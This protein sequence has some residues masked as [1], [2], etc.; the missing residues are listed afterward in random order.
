MKASL[1][2]LLNVL[3]LGFFVSSLEA[4]D[5]VTELA[6]VEALGQLKAV[7]AMY[8][9]DGNASTIKAGETKTIYFDALDYKGAPTRVFAWLG[10][11]E[12]ASAAKPVPAVVLVQ[13]GGGT[14]FKDWVRMW[15]E[16]GYAAISIAVEGQTDERIKER[17]PGKWARH[18][19]AGPS[20]KG[21]YA[22][23]G[24][25]FKDQWM[26][27]AVAD[28]V[29]ANSLLRSLPEVDADNVGLMG[30]SWGGIITSTVIGIDTRFAFAIPTYGIG[31]LHRIDNQ[32]KRALGDDSLFQEVWDP[33]VRI[34]R[35]SMPAL[36]LSWPRDKHFA[37][38]IQADTYEAAP[39]VRMVSLVP[40]MKHSHMHGWSRP[41]SYA[42]ADSIVKTG[43]PWCVQTSVETDGNDVTVEFNCSKP[44]RSASLLAN[45][46][47]GHTSNRD[48]SETVAELNSNENGSWTVKASLPP[49]ASGWF[50]NIKTSGGDLDGDEDGLT[51][52]FG[53][54]DAELIASSDYSE[55]GVN[56]LSVN[57]QEEDSLPNVLIIGDSISIG[58]TPVVKELLADVANVQRVDGN[59]GDTNRGLALLDSWLK[60][61]QWDVIHFNWG[62]H[63][64][65]YRHPDSKTSGRRDKINGTV[66]VPLDEYRKNLESLVGQLEATGTTLIWANTTFVP[67]GEAGRFAGDELK[68][69]KVA[70]E[71]MNRHNVVTDDLH[72]MTSTF[73]PSLFVKPGNVHYTKE[74]YA[75]IAA[76]V[77]EQIRV[78]L[79]Q[80]Q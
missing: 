32:Y 22:D 57:D 53:Y 77:A 42:F 39:G 43:K 74:G 17:P 64:L 56:L 16:R 54:N 67:E 29:L 34:S 69:N 68:Y 79:I 13:G 4:N 41:E 31:G 50:V 37:L 75:T 49:G 63:D 5:Y 24:E 12:G 15:N 21:I 18:A 19:W 73:D 36:W 65:C 33:M 76:Q 30:I 1:C 6:A 7:P 45:F 2:T 27:H 38:D 25:P 72:T 66:S 14:A 44:L 35:A 71:I 70:E 23:S 11:P 51:D 3:F 61:T 46:G 20:R 80:E 48:W 47:S 52:R 28:T 58:Y 26:Y 78:A 62:L 40:G 59:S 8:D 10:I 60:D 55:I 9:A